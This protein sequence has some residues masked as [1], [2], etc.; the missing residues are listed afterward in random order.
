VSDVRDTTDYACQGD[1]ATALTG[2]VMSGIALIVGTR[3][4]EAD[5]EVGTIFVGA[6]QRA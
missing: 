6:L 2:A 5:R 4:G 1:W 3:F